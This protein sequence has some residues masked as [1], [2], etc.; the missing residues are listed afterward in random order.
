MAA[1]IIEPEI[2]PEIIKKAI[3][4]LKSND[5]MGERK[6]SDTSDVMSCRVG[7]QNAIRMLEKFTVEGMYNTDDYIE[8][9]FVGSEF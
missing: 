9:Y 3:E 5:P 7:Y 6:L 2:K 8:G 1:T 4:Y